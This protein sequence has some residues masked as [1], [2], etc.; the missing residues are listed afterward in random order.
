MRHKAAFF[1][2]FRKCSREVL[3]Y[4]IT[5]ICK[6]QLKNSFLWYY[7]FLR[8]LCSKYKN[9]ILVKT[10][11]TRLR[12]AKRRKIAKRFSGDFAFRPRFHLSIRRLRLI[13]RQFLRRAI[14]KSKFGLVGQ[15]SRCVCLSAARRSRAALV[16]KTST[17]TSA[18]Q[19]KMHN[20]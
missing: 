7:A 16:S 1:A 4:V 20:D 9:E 14:G 13:W 8:P 2:S 12:T 5:R 18:K 11:K 19:L 3:S 15:L 17:R 10:H 6:N